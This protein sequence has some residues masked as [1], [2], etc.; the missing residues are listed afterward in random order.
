MSELVLYHYWRSSAAYRVR[1]ALNLKGLDY[2]LESVHLVKDGGQQH[3]DEFRALNPQGLVP[4]LIHEGQ[5]L[6]QSMAICEYLDER[7]DEY[8]LLTGDALQRARTRALALDVAC[9]IHPLNNL[10]VLQYT[11]AEF[12]ADADPKVWMQHWMQVGF[13]ALEK[14]LGDAAP[15]GGWLA[16]RVGLFECFLVPQV[17][18]AE[19]FELDMSQFPLIRQIT[20]RCREMPAFIKAAPEN[21]PDAT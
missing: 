2:Q 6:S 19:R 8:P 7:F 18:N 1:I 15:E 20:D 17:Y 11:K 10:R 9:D 16:S 5:V 14:R 3:Q 21:Q 4:V 13:T 12:G